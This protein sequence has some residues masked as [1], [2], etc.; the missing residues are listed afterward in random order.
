MHLL[1]SVW[2]V[3]NSVTLAL[4]PPLCA[5]VEDMLGVKEPCAALS[6]PGPTVGCTGRC[7]RVSKH[8]TTRRLPTFGR[9]CVCCLDNAGSLTGPPEAPAADPPP[10]MHCDAAANLLDS[11]SLLLWPYFFLLLLFINTQQKQAKLACEHHQCSLHK[12]PISR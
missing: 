2:G 11:E 1:P 12:V 4:S 7:G 3:A 10:P 8:A 6:Q 5:V 9:G